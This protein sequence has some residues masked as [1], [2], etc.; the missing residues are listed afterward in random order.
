MKKILFFLL[1]IASFTSLFSKNNYNKKRGFSLFEKKIVPSRSQS[2]L[3]G[4]FLLCLFNKNRIINFADKHPISMFVMVGFLSKYFYD[5][6]RLHM[7]MKNDFN[8]LFILQELYNLILYASEINN[9]MVQISEST[10]RSFDTDEHFHQMVKDLPFSF[11]QLETIAKEL[12]IKWKLKLKEKYPDFYFSGN[13]YRNDLNFV[14]DVDDTISYFYQNPIEA[15]QN[16]CTKIANK[17]T[18]IVQNILELRI[19]D[20]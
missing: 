6:H 3:L 13:Y 5:S 11:D 2:R 12:L 19:I 4:I 15:Y 10:D 20:L 9:T 18:I 7:K 16:A 17:I 8:I 1:L 14:Q